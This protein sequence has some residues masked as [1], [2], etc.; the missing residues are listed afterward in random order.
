MKTPVLEPL[1]QKVAGDLRLNEKEARTQVLYGEYCQ[2]FK[3]S[4][5]YKKF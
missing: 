4:F 3:Y 2:I 1:F 5:K